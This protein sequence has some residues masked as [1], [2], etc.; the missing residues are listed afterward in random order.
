MK[1]RAAWGMMFGVL[2]SAAGMA[3]APSMASADATS[4]GSKEN[5]CPLQGWMRKT[6]AASNSAGDM[7]SLEA[8]FRKVASMAPDK[9]WTGAD[10]KAH[11]DAIA[12]A[13][14]AAAKANDAA[15]VKQ[16]CKACHDA[17]KDKYKQQFRLR[18]VP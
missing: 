9:S 11:W 7:A 6:M 15:G 4:C 5:P 18:P 8:Q 16:A 17:Y 12:N 2:L 3:A 14:A 13:G 1:G 10:P